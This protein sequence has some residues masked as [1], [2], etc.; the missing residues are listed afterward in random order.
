MSFSTQV[1]IDGDSA[2]HLAAR[3]NHLAVCEILIQHDMA[4]WKNYRASMKTNSLS[5]QR[6]RQPLLLLG[7]LKNDIKLFLMFDGR[8]KCLLL[9]ALYSVM[10]QERYNS[11]VN[12][13]V[14]YFYDHFH[15]FS[16]TV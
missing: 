14:L 5:G 7:N 1:T 8:S 10:N 4:V 11:V 6:V 2:L 3:N 13:I 16:Y 12:R 15:I 9:T